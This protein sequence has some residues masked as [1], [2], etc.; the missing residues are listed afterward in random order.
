M[1][2]VYIADCTLYQ[3][4]CAIDRVL[5]RFDAHRQAK[6]RALQ[7]LSKKAQSAVAGLLLASVFGDNAIYQYNDRGK[8]YLA[9]NNAYFSLS[10][11]GKWVALA[12]SDTEIGFD[13][14]DSSPIRPAV[15]RRCFTPAEQA[16][17]GTDAER[18]TQLWVHKEAHGKYTGHGLTAPFADHTIDDTIPHC[19]GCWQTM[20]YALYGDDT[21]TITQVNV[22]V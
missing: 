18:F 10:H 2:R 4:A 11:C 21:I 13:L 8:P 6:I 9:D 12:V 1:T 17:I 22:L 16:W 19:D 5:P 20:R 3:D 15:L 7:N 14:Q